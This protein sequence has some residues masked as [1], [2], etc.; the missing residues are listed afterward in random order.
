[1]SVND[2][3]GWYNCKGPLAETPSLKTGG[4]LGA[5]YADPQPLVEVTPRHDGS[6]WRCHRTHKPRSFR[7]QL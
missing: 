3:W 6:W 1:M 5:Q 2:F 7:L 4:P